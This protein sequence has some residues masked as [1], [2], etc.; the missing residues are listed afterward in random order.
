MIN[1]SIRA[2]SKP[3]SPN[4]ITLPKRQRPDGYQEPKLSVR[5]IPTPF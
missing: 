3:L 5:H 1:T 4:N 2:T